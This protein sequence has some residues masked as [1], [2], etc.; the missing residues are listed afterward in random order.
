MHMND[1]LM[2]AGQCSGCEWK[3]SI[4][5]SEL[6]QSQNRAI[7]L[8]TLLFSFFSLSCCPQT[9]VCSSQTVMGLVIDVLPSSFASSCSFFFFFF[10]VSL[11]PGQTSMNAT[12]ET[13]CAS[14]TPT[15]STFRAATAAS[16]HRASS[17][18]P[19]GLV[20]VSPTLSE[21]S[22]TGSSCS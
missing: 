1:A 14:A 6:Q 2:Q 22:N 18:R 8:L 20:W 12:A 5:Q 15:A 21:M 19:T 11:P 17:C 9:P 16:A 13:T 10:F 7:M 3:P 4:I